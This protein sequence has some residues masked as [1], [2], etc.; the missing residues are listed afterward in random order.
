MK[1]SIFGAVG[2]NLGDEAIALASMAE[3][4]TYD[5]QIEFALA[6]LN[7]E[8]L[9]RLY[10]LCTFVGGRRNLAGSWQQIRTSSLV[11][12][13]GG[14]LIQ[15]ALHSPWQG[16]LLASVLISQMARAAAT[17]TATLA[18]GVDKLRYRTSRFLAKRLAGSVSLLTTRDEASKD[19]LTRLGVESSIYAAADPAFLLEER[20]PLPQ[21]ISRLGEN[22][23]C[24]SLLTENLE[25]DNYFPAILAAL[26]EIGH[27]GFG[28]VFVPM[29]DRPSEDSATI[30]RTVEALDPSIPYSILPTDMPVHEVAYILKRSKL[31]IGMRLHAMMLAV[32]RGAPIIGITRSLKTSTFLKRYSDFPIF[33]AHRP[34]I[35][36]DFS[37]AVSAALTRREHEV[38]RDKLKQAYLLKEDREK[39]RATFTHIKRLLDSSKSP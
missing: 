3:L 26:H 20:E 16:P 24:I 5:S 36:E 12:I 4:S 15:D 32:G 29:D 39:A 9:Q 18:I 25:L 21:I 28:L 19:E 14:T 2:H 1:I 23:V 7:P 13:G 38:E 6:S 27:A 8:R 22:Y 35:R 10:G 17:P 34:V 31:L 30:E 37:A 11:L 33:S